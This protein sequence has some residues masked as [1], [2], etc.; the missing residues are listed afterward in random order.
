MSCLSLINMIAIHLMIRTISYDA[1]AV[2]TRGLSTFPQIVLR[3]DGEII[4]LV[5]LK[6]DWWELIELVSSHGEAFAGKE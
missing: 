2:F 5:E 6:A 3:I 4:G 1:E